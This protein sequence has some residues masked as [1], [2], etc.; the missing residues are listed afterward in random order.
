MTPFASL[1]QLKNRDVEGAEN[2][3]QFI[4]VRPF[5]WIGPMVDFIPGIDGP[6]EGVQRVL[7]CFSNAEP[8]KNLWIVANQRTFIYINNAIE[9][10]LLMIIFNVGNPNNEVTVRQLAETMTEVY[11][12]VSREPVLETLAID[13]SSKEHYGEGYD[14][15]DKRILD[16]TI[17][18]RQLVMLWCKP[19]SYAI[20]LP[21]DANIRRD[22]GSAG[23][24]DTND[25]LRL[26]SLWH[27]MH[28]I[29]QQLFPVNGCF[30]IELL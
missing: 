4:I 6:S 14:D 30:G 23:R 19:P 21:F 17:I 26:A 7:P 11:T 16:M 9:A 29:S 3:L 25:S 15:S 1:G 24:M 8:L 22:Y 12:N 18:N 27:S 10:V 2:G 5:N 20:I 28:A 13:I